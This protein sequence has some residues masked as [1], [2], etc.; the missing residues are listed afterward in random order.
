MISCRPI[1]DLA[2]FR[3]HTWG[4]FPFRRRFTD[5][6][7]GYM[8]DDRGFHVICSSDLLCTWCHT[9]AYFPFHMRFMILHRYR[10]FDDRW[11]HDA[12]SSTYHTFDAIL[13]HITILDE[14]YRSWWSCVLMPICERRVSRHW[15]ICCFYD[16]SS[17]GPLGSCLVRPTLL[18]ASMSSCFPSERRPSDLWVWFSC[19]HRWLRSCIR[20]WVIWAHL[21]FLTCHRFDATP[22][23]IPPFRSRFVDSPLICM[24]TLGFEIHIG[25]MIWFHYVL[26]LRGAFLDSFSRIRISWYS[27]DSWTELP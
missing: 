20:W 11:F 25:L 8:C 21:V 18:Y 27:R 1:S 23:H 15:S 2:Y 26:I 5:L 6:H 13:G 17:V 24:T 10:M 16:D 7:R 9:G 12:R 4:I 3:C 22:G 19:I 14:I